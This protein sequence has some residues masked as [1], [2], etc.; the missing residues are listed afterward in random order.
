MAQVWIKWL[1]LDRPWMA[2]EDG[3]KAGGAG[4]WKQKWGE[5][6]PRAVVCR[7]ALDDVSYLDICVCISGVEKCIALREAR[8]AIR[9][10][11]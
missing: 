8:R 6:S 4:N 3:Q 7:L 9:C 1:I 11:E 5:H 10:I 2:A